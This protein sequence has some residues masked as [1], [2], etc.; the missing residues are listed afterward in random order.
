[1]IKITFLDGTVK[2]INE[3]TKIVACKATDGVINKAP[4]YR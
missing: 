2:T 4:F 3:S 1:M